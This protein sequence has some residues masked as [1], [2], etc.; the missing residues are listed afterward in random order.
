VRSRPNDCNYVSGLTTSPQLEDQERHLGLE[1]SLY[2]FQSYVADDYNY[3]PNYDQ[4]YERFNDD[5]D[6]VQ[7][8]AKYK[9]GQQ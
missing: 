8:A 1:I 9:H 4:A 7:P 5:I 3:N 6:D 2:E